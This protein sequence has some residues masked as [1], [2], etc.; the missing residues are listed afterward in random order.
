[1]INILKDFTKYLKAFESY[2]GRGL[3]L[4]FFL[5]ILAGLAEG[6][7]IS[8]LLPLLHLFNNQD[9]AESF[10]FKGYLFKLLE[11]LN[12]HNS[13]RI[14]LFLI[15]LA[16]IVKGI[17]IFLTFSYNSFLKGRL[18]VN[19]KKR[20]FYSYS[21]MSFEY[22]LKNNIGDLTNIINEQVNLSVRAFNSLYTVGLR[23][24][25]CII[26]LIFAYSISGISSF[27][28]IIGSFIILFIFR[29]L[30]TATKQISIKTANQNSK[31]SN[32]TIDSLNSFKYLKAT[33]Q[34]KIKF[35]QIANH[36]NTL[37]KYQIKTGIFE[38][39]T[40]AAREPISVTVIILII[41]VQLLLIKKPIDSLLVSIILFYRALISTL[42]VQGSWQKTQ[43]YVGSLEVVLNKLNSLSKN[44]EKNGTQQII[45]FKKD[46]YFKNVYFK[47]DDSKKYILKDL[48]FRL[49]ANKSI[50][51]VGK[52]GSGK[53]TLANLICLLLKPNAGE[54]Y[55]DNLDSSDI[56]TESWR[57]QIGYVSQETI[58]FDDTISNNISLS[59]K[60]EKGDQELLSRIK[61]SAA[62]AN[63]DQFI[64]SLPDGYETYVG[65]SGLKLSGG[66]RQ[67][68][69][70]ARE[71]FR[72]PKLLILDEATSA[73][74]NISEKA[75][76]KSIDLLK[77]KI[78]VILIAHRIS[79]LKNTD[80]LYVLNEGKIEE[81]GTF[82][83]LSRN[84]ESFFSKLISNQML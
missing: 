41:L 20:L 73:L 5:T 82:K 3:Y 18:L 32:I 84:E 76:Q 81:C 13:Y 50:A 64:E 45:K 57:D 2:I 39:F 53:T 80:Y 1:M 78:T 37:S 58:I 63:I 43:E 62:Q 47:F 56:E 74:D 34:F 30:N 42:G 60:K 59:S 77:G 65:G 70:I 28:A 23:S 6:L 66:Q 48:N 44:I 33:N 22:F 16:F 54:I 83:D 12:L 52:S 36:I 40:A 15:I 75:I 7:G 35:N 71:L 9:V 31:L 51:F 26:Y 67:R 46:I 61:D 25:Y 79:T 19:L 14:I 49:P 55:I 11:T 17:F 21:K 72:N 8:L 27:I 68:I 69:F 29:W 24:I 4:S 38:G 10:G